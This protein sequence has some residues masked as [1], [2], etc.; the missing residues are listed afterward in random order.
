VSLKTYLRLSI[1]EIPFAKS[2]K[3]CIVHARRRI[4]NRNQVT[5]TKGAK[6]AKGTKKDP[7]K[8]NNDRQIKEETRIISKQA[9]VIGANPKAYDVGHLA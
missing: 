8:A 9:V 7:Q 1:D 2:S 4:A 5:Q 3:D 6:G